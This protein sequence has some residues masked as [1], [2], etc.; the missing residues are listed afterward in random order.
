MRCLIACG[1]TGGH[2]YPGI[3]IAESVRDSGGGVVF[4]TN[5]STN[6]V[7]MVSRC[8]FAD[9]KTI[10]IVGLDRRNVLK[11]IL[12]PFKLIR[13]FFQSLSIIR[14]FNPDV[15]IGMGNY[16]TVPVVIAAWVLRK[17]VYLQEQNSI[18]GLANKVLRMFARNVFTGFPDMDRYFGS[19]AVYTG[20]PL[21]K[22]MQ[23]DASHSIM[24]DAYQYFGISDKFPVV[25]VL[26][27]S[28]GARSIIDAILGNIDCIISH[29]IQVL[30]SVGNNYDIGN[31]TSKYKVDST[32][33]K[34]VQCIERM[35]YA[36]GVASLVVS[37][38]GAMTVSEVCNYGKPTI[39]IPSP[40]V[41]NDHQTMNAR[42]LFDADAAIYIDEKNI[43]RLTGKI[44]GVISDKHKLN[45]LSVNIRRYA[46]PDATVDIMRHIVI[47][48]NCDT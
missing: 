15:V 38:A 29:G 6:V 42:F 1:G 27:G 23:H 21:R 14:K 31:V 41:T 30:L 19:K 5:S 40:N 25:L 24:P 12:L 2:V 3:A 9:V 28:L 7:G 34:V 22:C 46:R 18:P 44:V 16:V 39:F 36:Y 4:V 13:S 8:G 47:D 11:N 33:V 45:E 20:N 48:N 32:Y 10:D 43:R 17:R 35:D 26:G 37:R